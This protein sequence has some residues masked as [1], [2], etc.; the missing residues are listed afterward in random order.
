MSNKGYSVSPSPLGVHS[1]NPFSTAISSLRTTYQEESASQDAL[2]YINMVLRSRS[3]S[4]SQV[5]HG[6]HEHTNIHT[7]SN[8]GTI[9]RP[10]SHSVTP[11]ASPVVSPI[12]TQ[13]SPSTG[14][15]DNGIGMISHMRSA[16]FDESHNIAQPIPS[17]PAPAFLSSDFTN[18]EMNNIV[19]T[20]LS[21][22]AL[23]D[24]PH[25]SNF[26]SSTDPSFVLQNIFAT[27]VNNLLQNKGYVP[28][29]QVKDMGKAITEHIRTC[30]GSGFDSPQEEKLIQTDLLACMMAYAAVELQTEIT[31]YTVASHGSTIR[32]I[33][34]REIQE[35]WDYS[36]N[37][38]NYLITNTAK[39]IQDNL[40]E[41]FSN[42][43]H[44]NIMAITSPATHFMN[45]DKHTIMVAIANDT[46]LLDK[47]AFTD[48]KGHKCTTFAWLS[49]HPSP[50][51]SIAPTTSFSPTIGQK[52]PLEDNQDTD[53]LSYADKLQAIRYCLPM[54]QS[55]IDTNI[56]VWTETINKHLDNARLTKSDINPTT[57]RAHTI[58]ATEKLMKREYFVTKIRKL[59]RTKDQSALQAFAEERLR[60]LQNEINLMAIVEDQDATMNDPPEL[61]KT[62]LI[63][64]TMMIW[65]NTAKT[66][67]QDNILTCKQETLDQATPLLLLDDSTHRY[68]SLSEAEIYDTELDRRDAIIAK[69]TELN[70]NTSKII[71]DIK[72][73]SATSTNKGKLALIK[74]QGWD[75]AKHTVTQ[76]PTKFSLANLLISWYLKVVSDIIDDLKDKEDSTWETKIIKD[77]KNKGL[78]ATALD[79]RIQAIVRRLNNFKS[80]A[81]NHANNSSPPSPQPQPSPRPLSTIQAELMDQEMD[82]VDPIP[83]TD[84]EEYKQNQQLWINSASETFEKLAP[85]FQ[86]N[87]RKQKEE[88]FWEAADICAHQDK[89]LLQLQSISSFTD[90]NKKRELES[91][92]KLLIDKEYQSLLNATNKQE[93]AQKKDNFEDYLTLKD[94]DYY[95]QHTCTKEQMSNPAVPKEKKAT[96]KK[97]LQDAEKVKWQLKH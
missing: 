13:R 30:I 74:K 8:T 73:K 27:N 56:E 60:S 81:T 54:P 85:Y 75:A 78:Q 88:L 91:M 36:G 34:Y 79:S 16:A 51:K 69:I 28:S 87:E 46:P 12:V 39:T 42:R 18:S 38:D 9:S 31:D 82:T 49:G 40:D 76:N 7:D 22:P 96:L 2:Q 44:K 92:H 64:K 53:D 77:I 63:H 86:P 62:E 94:F 11:K 95:V 71:Q 47:W 25:A 83:W 72:Q 26:P 37:S 52:R 50:K 80:P 41:A 70:E 59:A 24:K 61:T 97:L 89:D 55:T 93:N 4:P 14:I 65:K 23:V 6:N 32:L 67:R 20:L 43:Q 15:N 84:T 48:E 21:L 58:Q 5:P 19:G 66:L 29:S 17:H 10:W 33:I 45:Q 90:S 57:L 35:D 1:P 68:A 3:T